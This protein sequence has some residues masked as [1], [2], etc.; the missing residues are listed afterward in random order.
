MRCLFA[1]TALGGGYT[2]LNQLLHEDHFIF[3]ETASSIM[4]YGYAVPFISWAF[5]SGFAILYLYI[6]VY[7]YPYEYFKLPK[8][9]IAI[10]VENKF[11]LYYG[12]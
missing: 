1:H 11:P 2:W 9:K 3:M 7:V 4:K 5:R 12:N 6:C 10:Q 8:K